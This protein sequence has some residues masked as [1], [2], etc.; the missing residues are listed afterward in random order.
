MEGG[1]KEKH[2]RKLSWKVILK[3]VSLKKN[4]FH[5]ESLQQCLQ[6]QLPKKGAGEGGGT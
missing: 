3:S 6:K 2:S 4:Q 5:D 1:D